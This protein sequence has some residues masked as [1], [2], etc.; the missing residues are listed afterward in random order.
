MRV[1]FSFLFF[2]VILIPIQSQNIFKGVVKDSISRPISDVNIIANLNGEITH[3]SYSNKNGEYSLTFT[4]YGVYSVSFSSVGFK[5]QEVQFHV[6]KSIKKESLVDIVLERIAINLDQIV[7]KSE[8]PV[9]V[10]KDTVLFRT[11]FFVKGNE[12]TVEDLLKRIPGLNIEEDGTIKVGNKEIEK[13]MIDGDDLFEKGYKIL[14]KNMPAYP[15]EEVELLKNYS[16]NRLLKG[17]EESD[18]VALNLK[19]NDEIKGLWFGNA[20]LSYELES[21]RNYEVLNNVGKFNKSNKHYFLSGLNN[22]GNQIYDGFDNLVRPTQI[23]SNTS[24][25][26]NIY[27]EE[28]IDTSHPLINLGQGKTNFNDAELLSL[29]TIFKPSDKT[30]LKI[31][32]FLNWD[33]LAFFRNT[34][35]FTEVSDISFTN[36]ENYTLNNRNK[37]GYGKIEFKYDIDENKLFE[38]AFRYNSELYN[39][40]AKNVF[41]GVTSNENTFSENE[42]IDF[43]FSYSAKVAE[44]KTLVI[45]GRHLRDDISQNYSVDQFLYQ[46]LFPQFPNAKG[47][48]Q[49]INN[50]VNFTGLR[51]NFLSRSPK[52]HL[53]E[54]QLGSEFRNE[55]LKTN[56]KITDENNFVSEPQNFSNNSDFK[57]REYY[58]NLK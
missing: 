51:I 9:V 5:T 1:L 50:S 54:T 21:G 12:Q 7:V 34:L 14:S 52:G 36:S 44:Q 3:Y 22:I 37:T 16:T 38:S 19:I 56:F 2:L 27:L 10:K 30:K 35:S 13:L 42:F 57:S 33:E 11:K 20:N 29:N 43:Q 32:G 46:N 58:L 23:N 15:V 26:G 6:N 53:F 39:G 24:I 41:N 25:G 28:A 48:N 49:L 55:N 45:I 8:K 31:Q 4:K 40:T 47:V 18:K 17:V